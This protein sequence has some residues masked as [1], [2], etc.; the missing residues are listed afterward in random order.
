[1]H[2]PPVAVLACVLLLGG[3]SLLL[4]R[5]VGSTRNRELDTQ[6][7]ASSAVETFSDGHLNPIIQLQ[8]HASGRTLRMRAVPKQDPEHIWVET[9]T[10]HPGRG[11]PCEFV[12]RADGRLVELE[13]AAQVRRGSYAGVGAR[14]TASS[15]ARGLSAKRLD[16]ETCGHGWTAAPHELREVSEF[17]RRFGAFVA[18]QQGRAGEVIRRNRDNT[19]TPAAIGGSPAAQPLSKELPAATPPSG[20]DDAEAPA[21]ES[22]RAGTSDRPELTEGR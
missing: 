15:I 3:C 6:A 19:Q 14:V 17:M 8:T 20:Q 10:A 22:S 16:G 9:V 11:A 18:F 21:E 13:D 1:M 7:L 12:L 4:S 2:P 5:G